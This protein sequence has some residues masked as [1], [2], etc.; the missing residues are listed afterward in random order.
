MDK[1]TYL[2]V[3]YGIAQ[4]N[5]CLCLHLNDAQFIAARIRAGEMVDQGISWRDAVKKAVGEI[6]SQAVPE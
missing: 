3:T 4:L 6:N 5:R 2:N 1:T